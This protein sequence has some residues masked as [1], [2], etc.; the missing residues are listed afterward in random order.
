M[1]N[2][3][4]FFP[5]VRADLFGGKLLQSQVEG[6]F[7]ILEEWERRNLADL[8][9]LAYILATAYWETAKTMQPIEEYGKGKGKPYGKVNEKTG[10]A[11]YGRGA[12]Q[13][14]W[15][16]NYARLSN[17]AQKQKHEWDF[18]NHPELLLQMK[19]SIWAT[20]H[21]MLTG[22]YTGKA[23][24]DYFNEEKELWVEA[25]R[26]INGKDK[27]VEIANI[28]RRFYNILLASVKK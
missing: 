5:K 1:I 18:I 25:R 9:W 16:S 17:E 23:L 21:G 2:Q 10:K 11:Y 7:A 22:L 4:V 20:F 26:I 28:A 12:V 27:A 8:R 19:P 13:V 14:T 3:A 15:L 24:D 6:L